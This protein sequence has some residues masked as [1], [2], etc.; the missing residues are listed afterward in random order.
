[1]GGVDF[2]AI[3]ALP[4]KQRTVGPHTVKRLSDDNIPSSVGYITYSVFSLSGLRLY[5]LAECI[6]K[7]NERERIQTV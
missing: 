7:V 3:C 6:E 4:C 5:S 1:M 2:Q